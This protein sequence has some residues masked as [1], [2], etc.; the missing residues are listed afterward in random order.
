MV[1]D[2]MSLYY[3]LINTNNS[4]VFEIT[5]MFNLLSCFQEQNAIDCNSSFKGISMKF[6]ITKNSIYK[7]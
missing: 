3:I 7:T 1:S 2:K 4:C 6:D 5:K